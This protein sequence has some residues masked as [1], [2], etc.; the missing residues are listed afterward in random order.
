LRSKTVALARNS[1]YISAIINVVVTPYCLNP[2]EGNW[3]GKSGFLAGGLSLLATVWAYFRLPE[4]SERTYLEIDLLFK[5][6][7][8]ARNFSKTEV[9]PYGGYDQNPEI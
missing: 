4:F 7:V 8:S 2:T 9:D 6:G 3:K 5:N 1:Y